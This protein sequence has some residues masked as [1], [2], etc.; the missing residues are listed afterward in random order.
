VEEDSS[1]VNLPTEAE[2]SSVVAHCPLN[3]PCH[4]CGLRHQK[5]LLGRPRPIPGGGYTQFGINY[6]VNDFVL[7][8]PH[9]GRHAVYKVAQITKIKAMSP[10]Q[11]C[12]RL[13]RRYRHEQDEEGCDP[14]YEVSDDVRV[15][16]F[17][18]GLAN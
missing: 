8:K 5:E 13:F 10:F 7:V 14:L 9:G 15:V 4:P 3:E 6:H 18:L 16:A 2:I 17:P 11:V 12:L 1:L